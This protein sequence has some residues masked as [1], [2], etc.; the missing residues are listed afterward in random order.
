MPAAAAI[1][2]PNT[3]TDADANADSNGDAFADS[4]SGVEYL[5]PAPGRNRGQRH[6]RRIY[7][8]RERTQE[9]SRFVELDHRSLVL[10]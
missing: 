3:D 9:A 6:D 5:H 2:D 10:V 4:S 1:A 8:H 7:H